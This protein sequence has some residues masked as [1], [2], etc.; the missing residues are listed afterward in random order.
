MTA[1]ALLGAVGGAALGYVTHAA[2]KRSETTEFCISCHVMDATVFEELKESPHYTNASGF[3]VQ[4]GQCHI[5]AVHSMGEL[6]TYLSVK[7]GA[8]RFVYGWATGRMSEPEQL[9]ANREEM[10]E[11]V[12]AEMR[13]RDSAECRACHEMDAMDLSLQSRRAAGEHRDA[14]EEGQT[15]ID[16]HDNGVAHAPIKK[17]KSNEEEEWGDDAFRIE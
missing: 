11:R 9:R 7:V 10:A 14:A 4:C 17:K 5:P 1:I 6:M 3:R 15:C 16:C 13:A 8:A 2:V 12:W